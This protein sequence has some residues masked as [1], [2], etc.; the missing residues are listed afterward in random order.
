MV[1]NFGSS[2]S[3]LNIKN[4][5]I[6]PINGKIYHGAFADFGGEED[7]V[8]LEKIKDLDKLLSKHLGLIT[9]SVNW[10]NKLTFP[11]KKLQIISKYN[12]IPIVR[13][14]PRDNFDPPSHSKPS[15]YSLSSILNGKWDKDIYLFAKKTSKF[16]KPIFIDFAPEMNG[17][18]FHWSGKWNGGKSSNKYGSAQLPDGPERFRDAYRHI[19][20][21]FRINK[22]TN[23][24]WIFHPDASGI[25]DSNW[26]KIQN[27]YPGD[28][29]IDWLGV[30]IYGST[31]EKDQVQSFNSKMKASYDSL[32]KLNSK[33]PIILSEFGVSEK[34]SDSWLKA[35]WLHNAFRDILSG[36]Y[37]NLYG[38]NYWHEDWKDEKANFARLKIDSSNQAL[39]VY[40]K[41]IHFHT[42]VP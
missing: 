4:N 39:S 26:N 5:K 33:S 30:S 22:A 34:R 17:D 25:Q 16:K 29:Y 13:L 18:W 21:I 31:I 6:V 15:K 42:F 24:T 28:D 7:Q 14:M 23:V 32:V 9:F 20:D 11:A 36:K 37:K 19:I 8:S 41:F 27:Y 10:N 12:A 3:Y 1:A 2:Q 35:N 38:I 40:R